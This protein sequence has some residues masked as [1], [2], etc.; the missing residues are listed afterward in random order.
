MN[1]LKACSIILKIYQIN[2]TLQP[3]KKKKKEKEKEM[4]EE[5]EETGI[6]SFNSWKFYIVTLF[7]IGNSHHS[8]SKKEKAKEGGME[9]CQTL[10]LWVK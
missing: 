4:K 7:P 8:I 1:I 6:S 10:V 5:E 9:S 2:A 3:L